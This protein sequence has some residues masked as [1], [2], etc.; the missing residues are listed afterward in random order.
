MLINIVKTQSEKDQNQ[1]QTSKRMDP[2]STQQENCSPL[3]ATNTLYTY[4]IYT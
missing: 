2:K 4:Q 3:K 1:Q